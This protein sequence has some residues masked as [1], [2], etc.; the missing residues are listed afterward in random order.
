VK[1]YRLVEGEDLEVVMSVV[2]FEVRWSD[3]SE[4][5]LRVKCTATLFNV[6]RESVE[7][8]SALDP[9]TPDYNEIQEDDFDWQY[10]FPSY[11]PKP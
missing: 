2:E 3:L 11:N 7:K 1:E 6:Y 9:P 10:I 5:R 4:G 8:S